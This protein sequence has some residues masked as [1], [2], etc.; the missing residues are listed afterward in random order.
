MNYENEL[1][2]LTELNELSKTSRKEI[3]RLQKEQREFEESY[4]TTIRTIVRK[5][6]DEVRSIVLKSGDKDIKNVTIRKGLLRLTYKQKG[7]FN[8]SRTATYINEL[9]KK[10]SFL[11]CVDSSG[12]NSYN[13]FN[14][15]IFDVTK[16]Y[17]KSQYGIE[18]F[19]F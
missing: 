3:N 12:H 15:F 7:R 19:K 10:P 18:P 11:K 6:L 14:V 2:H 1:K 4:D 13:E 17:L 8:L 9:S 5:E 16:K